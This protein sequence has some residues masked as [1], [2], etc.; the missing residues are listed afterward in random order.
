VVPGG[1]SS[2][3]QLQEAASHDPVVAEHYKDFNYSRARV[4]QVDQ[5]RLVYVSYRH[6]NHVYWT[7]KRLSLHKGEKLLSDGRVTARARC[8]NQVSVLPQANIAPEEPT[9]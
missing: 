6:K 9:E 4:I 3:A 7:H 1:V 2:T 8:G 5:P